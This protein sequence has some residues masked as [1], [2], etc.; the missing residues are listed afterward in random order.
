VAGGAGDAAEHLRAVPTWEMPNT[1][2]W[3]GSEFGTPKNFAD[4]SPAM[5]GPSSMRCN[6]LV[7]WGD[8][9]CLAVLPLT[10]SSRSGTALSLS[11]GES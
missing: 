9:P 10:L 1:S 7:S 5:I 2:G 3:C 6:R 8:W 11:S 4:C